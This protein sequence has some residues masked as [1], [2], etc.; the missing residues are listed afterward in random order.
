MFFFYLQN[1]L[2]VIS[3]F[4]LLGFQGSQYLRNVLFFQF[5][6]LFGAT[7]CGNLLIIVLV[8]SSRS[9]HTPMYFF[10][11]QLSISDILL[12]TNIIPNMLHILLNNGGTITFTGCLTQFHFFGLTLSFECFLLPAMSYDRYVAVCNPL[13]YISI[14]RSVFCIQLVALCWMLG[15]LASFILTF[16]SS[17][18]HYCG[19]NIDHFYCDIVP[20]LELACSN[21]FIVQMEIY[22][23]GSPLFL[24]QILIIVV[25]YTCI[26]LAVLRIP[27]SIGRQK[28][29][30]TC[31]SHLIVVSIFYWTLFTV[32]VFPIKGQLSTINKVVS[33]LYTTFTPL[34]NPII[35]SL[36]NKDIKK[37]VEQTL[38]KH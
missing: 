19:A 24:S 21:A 37:A 4:F 2:T 3:E 33:L 27:S 12:T 25:S 16:T 35:Y 28:A 7:I 10:I 13:Q 15:F 9:L 1:N 32:Y 14:M 11:S 26:V 18:F 20:L 23:I 5:L 31:S 38:R 17:Q 36:K 34:M 30:S 6:I 22:V 8:S 29:F